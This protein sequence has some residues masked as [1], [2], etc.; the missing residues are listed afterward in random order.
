MK[1]I[2]LA[3]TKE[4]LGISTTDYDTKISR[5]IPIIDSKVKLITNK[6]YNY[7]VIGDTTADSKIVVL[8][9]V[10][11]NSLGVLDFNHTWTD[12]LGINNYWTIEDLQEYLEIGSLI[13]G[14]SIPTDAYIDEVYYNGYSYAASS[15]SYTIPVIELNEAATET[16]TGLQIF[17][18]FNIGL[19]TTVAKG[20]QWLI[21]QEGTAL[22]TSGLKSKSIGPT[23]KTWSDKDS[24]I[25]GKSGMPSWFVKSFPQYMSGH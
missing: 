20:I 8:R 10:S 5:Y 19:Q 2:T 14:G 15:E 24:K 4:L 23:S 16:A 22:P 13:S 12:S 11:N 3:K 18:G 7:Q 9:T 6:R 21:E 17:I 25:D 1:I